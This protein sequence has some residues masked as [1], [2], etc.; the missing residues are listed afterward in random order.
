MSARLKKRQTGFAR[1]GEMTRPDVE[2]CA[3]P[4]ATPQRGCNALQRPEFRLRT[5]D[6]LRSGSRFTWFEL[7][8]PRSAGLQPALT[9]AKSRLQTGAPLEVSHA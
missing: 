2:T 4:A 5:M 9:A 7:F 6:G 8:P 1:H 3:P